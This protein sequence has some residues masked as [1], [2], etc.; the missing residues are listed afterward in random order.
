[1]LQHLNLLRPSYTSTPSFQEIEITQPSLILTSAVDDA[2]TLHFRLLRT[3]DSPSHLISDSKE[4]LSASDV[5]Y[6][7]SS[8]LYPLST[9]L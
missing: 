3:D 5:S 1:M 4:V 2:S 7:Q 9:K 8:Q 6:F